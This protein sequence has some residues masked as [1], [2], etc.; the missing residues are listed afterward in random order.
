VCLKDC[1]ASYATKKE[2]GLIDN[3]S[4]KTQKGVGGGQMSTIGLQR[5]YWGTSKLRSWRG[6]AAGRRGGGESLEMYRDSRLGPAFGD[7]RR[8]AEQEKT[9]GEEYS[10]GG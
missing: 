8:W 5:F 10:D 6:E 2:E 1:R 7:S 3:R 4:A 9:K